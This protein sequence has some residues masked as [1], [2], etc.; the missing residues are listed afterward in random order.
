MGPVR[1]D[2][3]EEL[4]IMETLTQGKAEL[5]NDNRGIRGGQNH[6]KSMFKNRAVRRAHVFA[7]SE[8]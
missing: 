4:A 2:P 6:I 1:Y 7:K 3:R 8:F 5:M